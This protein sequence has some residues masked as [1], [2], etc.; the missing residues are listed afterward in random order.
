MFGIVEPV[1]RPAVMKVEAI[2]ILSG[3]RAEFVVRRGIFD[4]FT[5]EPDDDFRI[6]PAH[7]FDPCGRN[8]HFLAR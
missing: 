7:P 6:R 4:G 3:D 2:F 5:R 1:R 8:Q